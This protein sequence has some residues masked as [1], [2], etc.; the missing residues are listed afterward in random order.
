VPTISLLRRFGAR[1][2]WSQ[3]TACIGDAMLELLAS[4]AAET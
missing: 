3:T 1:R 2:A 4:I